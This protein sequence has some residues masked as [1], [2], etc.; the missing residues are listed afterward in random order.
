MQRYGRNESR[1][2]KLRKALG[3][4]IPKPGLAGIAGGIIGSGVGSSVGFLGA[5]ARYLL[6]QA[7]YLMNG[8]GMDV[9]FKA[10]EQGIRTA[11]E[12]GLIG[13]LGGMIFF[14]KF[15]DYVLDFFGLK[16]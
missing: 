9:L 3:K 6:S 11:G 10:Y 12:W 16:E 15:R 13:G 14:A 2:S 7:S 1:L 5:S 8:G 4:Y